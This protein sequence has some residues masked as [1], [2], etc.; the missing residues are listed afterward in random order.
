MLFR[1]TETTKFS[2]GFT[3]GIGAQGFIGAEYFVLPKISVGAQYT[4]GAALRFTGKS[5]TTVTYTGTDADPTDNYS[6]ETKGSTNFN[7][8][9]VGVAS[10]TMNLHF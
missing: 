3:F 8:G 5:K 7:I 9:P 1:S 6:T 10:V 4:F 2:K